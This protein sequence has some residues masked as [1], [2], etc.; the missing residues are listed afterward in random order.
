MRHRVAKKTLNRT[1]AHRSSL[2]RNLSEALITH[3]TIETTIDKAK[4]V[5]P[6]VEKLVTKAKKADGAEKVE[7]FNLVKYLRTRL[8]TEVVIRKLVEEVAPLFQTRN[9][10]YTRIVRTGNRDGDNAVKARVE[11]VETKNKQ[12]KES[13]KS[14]LVAKTKG[15]KSLAEKTATKVEESKDE[16]K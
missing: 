7:L 13:E 14:K 8:Y 5:K 1:S 15:K 12:T 3:G 16:Q 9:G 4:F 2:I 6:Y 10:G 11:F